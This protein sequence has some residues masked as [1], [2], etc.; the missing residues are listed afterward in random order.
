M[1]P[2]ITRHHMGSGSY[3]MVEYPSQGTS[4]EKFPPLVF[5]THSEAPVEARAP[6]EASAPTDMFKTKMIEI[7]ESVNQ[8]AQSLT[9]GKEAEMVQ[10]VDEWAKEFFDQEF[11]EEDRADALCFLYQKLETAMLYDAQTAKD[12][13]AWDNLCIELKKQLSEVLNGQDVDAYLSTYQKNE[14]EEPCLDLLPTIDAIKGQFFWIGD[15]LSQELSS[16]SEEALAKMRAV[17]EKCKLSF[18]KLCQ[19][20]EELDDKVTDAAEEL[21]EVMGELQK[22]KGQLQE[23]GIQRQKNYDRLRN[24]RHMVKK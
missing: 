3:T 9:P 11:L 10:A 20:V 18:K 14:M 7:L 12:E 1:A 2:G 6:A 8:M 22:L 23:I 17:H 15:L 5:S 21:K 4:F 19:K 16:D 24:L 13:V